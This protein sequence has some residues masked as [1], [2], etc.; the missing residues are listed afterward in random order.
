MTNEF[1]TDW[2]VIRYKD[3]RHMIDRRFAEQ[4]FEDWNHIKEEEWFLYTLSVNIIN[5]Q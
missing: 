5:Q 3:N 4:M 1:I 2:V